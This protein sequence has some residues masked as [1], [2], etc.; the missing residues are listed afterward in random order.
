MSISPLYTIHAYREDLFKVV[1]FKG[2]RDPDFIKLRADPVKNDNKLA[3]NYSRARSMVLQYAL[4]N[5]WEYFFTGTLDQQKYNRYNL[6]R[7][8]VNLSQFVRDQRKKWDS[9]IQVL[10]IPE[11]HKDGAWHVH[12]LI[13]DLPEA[14]IADFR[15][16][17][18]K[19]LIENG[20]RNWPDFQ[21][22]FGFCSLGQ[23]RNVIGTA[24][25]VSKYI[26]KDMS[27]RGRDLGKHLYFHSRPLKTAASA[28]EVYG[29]NPQLD[30]FCVND[31]D[32]CRT[33]FAFKQPWYFPYVWEYSDYD[34][35]LIV[36]EVDVDPLQEELRSF[37]PSLIDP[38]YEQ[39]KIDGYR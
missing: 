28:S 10:L 21:R 15:Y 35:S 24:F 37:D 32:F 9:Q 17:A 20:F 19:K 2:V 14:A 22:K 39:L 26:S 29:W 1:A 36:S 23:I 30:S 18:P 6:D 11:Q 33:G 12:G 5:P 27:Q 16:P 31:Y 25:Y 34:L 3:N 7:F 38:C 4:C 13:H 8:M